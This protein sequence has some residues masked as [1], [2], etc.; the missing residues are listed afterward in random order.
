MDEAPLALLSAS[1]PQS[2]FGGSGTLGGGVSGAFDWGVRSGSV[3]CSGAGAAARDDSLP[4]RSENDGGAAAGPVEACAAAD[5]CDDV[6]DAED[7]LAVE[8]LRRFFE[9]KWARVR[10]MTPTALP[11]A[12]GETEADPVLRGGV[13]KEET[14][15]KSIEDE[16]TRL[17]S[18]SAVASG[19]V[20]AA[21]SG[22][23]GRGGGPL[24]CLLPLERGRSGSTAPLSM[25]IGENASNEAKDGSSIPSP[26]REGRFFAPGGEMGAFIMS[27]ASTASFS[28]VSA[29]TAV[30]AMLARS[31]SDSSRD[32]WSSSLIDTSAAETKE[33]HAA[34]RAS[35]PGVETAGDEWEPAGSER[36]RV[37]GSEV[38]EPAEVRNEGAFCANCATSTLARIFRP[39]DARTELRLSAPLHLLSTSAICRSHS[40]ASSGVML[41]VAVVGVTSSDLSIRT[42]S[43]RVASLRLC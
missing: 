3:R 36:G 11:D 42:A 30:R 27:R 6:D 29:S 10:F 38:R 31:A 37:A 33:S 19:L 43:T 15:V 14:K 34:L 24:R 12:S 23:G 26:T 8:P 1:T 21:S 32:P 5:T 7:V 18:E 16:P 22:R 28:F 35:L 39:P 41:P 13:G 25:R 40:C 4:I 9:R 2:G 17:E 20:A